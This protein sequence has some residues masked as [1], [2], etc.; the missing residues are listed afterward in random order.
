MF[1]GELQHASTVLV[2]DLLKVKKDEIVVI[3]TD[4]QTDLSVAKAIAEVCENIQA[5]PMLVIIPAPESVSMAADKDIPMEA[6]SAALCEADVWIELNKQWLLYSTPYYNAK[7][8]N[9]A[10]R[11]M[12]LTGTNADTLI[13]CVGKVDYDAMRDFTVCLKE[14]LA[15]AEDVLMRSQSGD[16]VTFK[17][18]KGRP[19]SVK[20][21]NADVPGTHLFV[22]QIGWTPELS[23][24][25]GVVCLD[26][27]VAPDIGLISNPV[28]IHITDGVITDITGGTEAADYKA[29]LTGFGH[30]Q[31]LR[32]SHAGI[33]F[34]PGAKL[35]GDIL[36]DQRVWGSTTWGFGSIS[37]GMLP[38]AG[39]EAPSHS[40][41]VSLNT[42]I[43]L[44]GKAL[45]IN[46]KVVDPELKKLSEKFGK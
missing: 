19:I 34:N 28:K 6:I 27:S 9:K 15:A 11:H 10:L 41:A 32:V 21:G 3:T 18:V 31:M 2:K 20:M 22:G 25:N 14:K 7:K 46:G 44:D 5:K 26:G 16:E 24:V 40:D 23:S 42:D 36:Q 33:G 37:A 8:Y 43:Y 35:A 45:F 30:E 29:W 13:S 39:V 38:P 17:N 4:T 1:L 12:C